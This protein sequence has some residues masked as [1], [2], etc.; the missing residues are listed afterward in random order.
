MTFGSLYNSMNA[1]SFKLQAPTRR[2]MALFS[3]S[4]LS[5]DLRAGYIVRLIS[6]FYLYNSYLCC[7]RSLKT[8]FRKQIARQGFISSV[9]DYKPVRQ[10]I[11][12]VFNTR[13]L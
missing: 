4:S 8:V 9:F 6:V 10:A 13:P 12:Q 2:K 7:I 3:F 5:L 11:P 1:R